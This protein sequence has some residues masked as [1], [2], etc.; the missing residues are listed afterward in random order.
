[1]IRKTKLIFSIIFLLLLP[2]FLQVLAQSPT[3]RPCQNS[4]C[5]IAPSQLNYQCAASYQDWLSDPS[6][7][8]WVEDEE[9]TFL[10]K[11]AERARQ[12]L[13]WVLNRSPIYYHRSIFESWGSTRN[14]AFALVFLTAALAGVGIIVARRFTFSTKLDVKNIILK[15]LGIIL[16]V[17]FSATLVI[18][19]IQLSDILMR[20]FVEN[21]N[22]GNLFNIFF[23]RPEGFVL[24]DSE[25][26]YRSFVGCKNI[27]TQA[28]ESVKISIF[29]VKITNLTYF[30]IG[31]LL[32]IRQI[33]LW[34]LVAISPF[35]AILLFFKIVKNVGK[36][37]IGVFFQWVFY[38]PLVALFLGTVSKMWQ[39]GIPFNFN[40]TRA[41]TPEG[42]VYPTAISIL[43][44]GPSQ[45]LAFMNSSN[46]VDTF[47]EYVI[48]I[49]MLW[50]A[51]VLPWWLL[52]TFRDY[53]CDGIYAIKNLLMAFYENYRGKKPPSPPTPTP[54]DLKSAIK[55][56]L[57]IEQP[58]K[59]KIKIE[60]GA[61]QD[62]KKLR[63][64]D[65]VANINLKV[66]ALHDLV[67]IE[68]NKAYKEKIERTLTSL[69]QPDRIA[70]PK[71][72]E[73]I[74]QL[75]TELY[76]R[77]KK[78][79]KVAQRIL[80]ATSTSVIER[81]KV[82][83]E[84]IQKIPQAAPAQ[85]LV[86]STTKLP[87][88]Q[89]TNIFSN[90]VQN[91]VKNTTLTK[92]LSQTTQLPKEK[93]SQILIEFT[94]NLS[95]P[96][97]SVINKIS[98]TTQV[99]KEKIK[100][101]IKTFT[102]VIKTSSLISH[103]AKKE[104]VER[105][106]VKETIAKLTKATPQQIPEK[107][108][109]IIKAL[110]ETIL[111]K[112][113]LVTTLSHQTNVEKQVI[114]QILTQAKDEEEFKQLSSDPQKLTVL[115]QIYTTILQSDELVD[116]VSKQTGV[117]REVIEKTITEALPKVAE[118]EQ[119]IEQAVPVPPTVSI[120]EY[121][122]T[123]KLWKHHYLKGE[124]PVSENITSRK[125]WVEQD[126][127]YLTNILNKL[128]SDDEKLKEEAMEELSYLLPIFIINDLSPEQLLVYLKAKLEAAKEVKEELEKEEELKEKLKK[129]MEKEELVE[130][131][132]ERK[133]KEEKQKELKQELSQEL[134]EEEN[135]V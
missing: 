127:I 115:S 92:T 5:P 117:R 59:E 130:V 68:T 55:A 91:F 106:K 94:N 48:S 121:E 11:N 93:I 107:E 13:Y 39:Y 84:V 112:E 77:A 61:L 66:N 14:L 1:M 38:G 80:Q 40:F 24:S 96:L 22:V 72:R 79:D 87:P 104:K 35:L 74:M 113:E 15:L 37:W 41:N 7:N 65:I 2:L 105:E 131:P 108:T 51:I 97:T 60:L 123:K 42:F 10:G 133:K 82:K 86:A 45:Q 135:E 109:S 98:K 57:K 62:I 78:Q 36:I 126:I 29:L 119:N 21:L 120:E 125:E 8:F 101:T 118:A 114:K 50:A 110:H 64:T 28:V 56:A 54:P 44:G 18:T 33:I 16:Y 67:K 3:P 4:G 69:K 12:F 129:E 26:A 20:F 34:L 32:L 128:L 47:A 85:K 46:Y 76:Q 43:Y 23:T 58:A 9:I 17:T 19:I 75:K 134:P 27:S 111:Q 116:E 102:N 52:R 31:L 25:T 6:Q 73:K 81:E 30:L 88:Q 100:Q 90:L 53:C 70:N 122:N 83:K 71:E 99:E 89:I 95:L 49:L 63:T 132:L 103:T 124:V